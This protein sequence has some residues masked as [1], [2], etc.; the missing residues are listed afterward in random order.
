MKGVTLILL[1]KSVIF[2]PGNG[3]RIHLDL[4]TLMKHAISLKNIKTA[5]RMEGQ[6]LNIFIGSGNQRIASYRSS[7]LW[8]FLRW[9]RTKHG[10]LS[11]TRS[12]EIMCSPW[13]VCYQRYMNMY[14][15]FLCVYCMMIW[16]LCLSFLALLFSYTCSLLVDAQ[17]TTSLSLVKSL[18]LEEWTRGMVG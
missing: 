18:T 16:S 3:S 8:D 11:V 9:C 6:I 12:L 15:L 14:F 7:M 13:F 5:W 4:H 17:P 10:H 1:Q 2:F